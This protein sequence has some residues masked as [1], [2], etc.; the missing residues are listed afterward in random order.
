M[1]EPIT[2]SPEDSRGS[3]S[4]R[5]FGVTGAGS[6][7]GEGQGWGS[8]GARALSGSRDSHSACGE[9]HRRDPSSGLPLTGSWAKINWMQV[10]G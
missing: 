5:L 3:G 7:V 1:R 9:I 8:C 4:R 10:G 6:Q 2:C